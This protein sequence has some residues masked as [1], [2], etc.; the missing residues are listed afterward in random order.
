MI[1]SIR[2]LLMTLALALPLAQTGC[3]VEIYEIP[4]HVIALADDD[5]GRMATITPQQIADHIGFTNTVYTP[6]GIQFSF[7]PA[8]DWEWRWDTALNSMQ[9]SGSGWW[10]GP[11]AVAARYPGKIVI[12]LRWGGTDPVDRAGNGFAYPPDTGAPL[13]PDAVLPT[14]NVDFIAMPSNNLGGLSGGFLGHELGHYLGLYHTQPTWGGDAG[15]IQ[16]I[17]DDDGLPGLDGDGLSDTPPD[18]GPNHFTTN[19]LWTNGCDGSS[20]YT[21][22][23]DAVVTGSVV[24]TPDRANVMGYFR[25]APIHFSVQQLLLMR[26]TLQHEFRRHL[27]EPVCF[28]DHH[29]LPVEDFQRCVDYWTHKGRWPVTVSATQ[30]PGGVIGGGGPIYMTSS[31]QPG[32]PR[33]VRHLAT[34]GAYQST[35]DDAAARG[36]RPEQ[37]QG[38]RINGESRWNAVWTPAEG[39]FAS[40]HNMTLASFGDRWTQYGDLGWQLVDFNVFDGAGGMRF[41]ATWVDRPHSGYIAHYDMDAASYDALFDDYALLGWEVMRFSTYSTPYGKRYAALWHPAQGPYVHHP[42]QTPAEHQANY[43]ALTVQGFR[44]RQLHDYDGLISAIWTLPPAPSVQIGSLSSSEPSASLTARTGLV[45]VDETV[46]GLWA[47]MSA[48]QGGL[49]A[50]S[51]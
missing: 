43:D 17:L 8:T 37:V 26:E 11:N 29:R 33:Y 6:A 1:R 25:C 14:D 41:N 9:N 5:G 2:T 19:T 39:A 15:V 42:S 38:V 50:V 16:G 49:T 24:I 23:S 47:P 36:F 13:Q 4:I 35:F 21:A 31:I 28:P 32:A 18:A 27:I 7:D 40:F 30:N 34:S 20:G 46:E 45:S 3:E 10:E 44:I 12:F 22:S 48:E 51:R